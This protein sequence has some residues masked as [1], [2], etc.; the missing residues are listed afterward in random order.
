MQANFGQISFGGD[1]YLLAFL[2]LDTK[3]NVGKK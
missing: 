1:T 2:A 3:R